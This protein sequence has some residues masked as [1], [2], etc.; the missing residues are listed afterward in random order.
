MKK[1]EKRMIERTI[2]ELRWKGTD[3][4]D[5]LPPWCFVKDYATNTLTVV[6]RHEEGH[7]PRLGYGISGEHLDEANEMIG[8]SAVQ[9]MAMLIGS[10]VGWD[11]PGADPAFYEQYKQEVGA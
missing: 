2:D 10:M 3:I 7:L 6:E 11:V 5:G 1:I 9:R 4:V 8:V